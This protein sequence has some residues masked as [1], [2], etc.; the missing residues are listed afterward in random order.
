MTAQ[1]CYYKLLFTSHNTDES[2]VHQFLLATQ[3]EEN[4]KEDVDFF[5]V[6][7]TPYELIVDGVIIRGFVPEWLEPYLQH[8]KGSHT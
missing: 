6:Q 4:D 3:E 1:R 2:C 5:Y 7:E 8:Y